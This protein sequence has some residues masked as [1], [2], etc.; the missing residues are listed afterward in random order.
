MTVRVLVRPCQLALELP[1]FL[2]YE[3]IMKST[4]ARGPRGD[5]DWPGSL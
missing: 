2:A 4:A 1:I 5:L 3:I